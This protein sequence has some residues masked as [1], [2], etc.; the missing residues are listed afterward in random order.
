MRAG[1]K[2]HDV[3]LGAGILLIVAG[4]ALLCCITLDVQPNMLIAIPVCIIAAGV[5]LL[6]F[7]YARIKAIWRLFLGYFLTAAGLFALVVCFSSLSLSMLKL[8]PVFVIL[9]GIS[10]GVASFQIRRKLY[11]SIIVPA[12]M[13]VCLG[14]LFLCFSLGIIGISFRYFVS[15][16]WPSFLVLL[17][18]VLIM[19]YVYMQHSCKA[20]N[21]TDKV[22]TDS[23]EED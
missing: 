19:I 9:C 17:G 14:S 10:Y 22:I 20:D 2:T 23:D 21:S 6:I 11:V 13:L 5:A 1:K 12:V 4:I 7:S 16:W 8:W 3:I 18:I 15:R